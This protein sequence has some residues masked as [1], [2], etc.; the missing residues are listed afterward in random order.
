MVLEVPPRGTS[1]TDLP[2]AATLLF[3][4]GVGLQVAKPV[5]Q[6]KWSPDRWCPKCTPR[7]FSNRPL[8]RSNRLLQNQCRFPGRQAGVPEKMVFEPMVPEV[9][10]EALPLPT[11][12]LQQRFC[13]KPMSASRSP[14]RGSEKTVP[15]PM[16]P[17]MPPEALPQPTPLPRHQVCAQSMPAPMGTYWPQSPAGIGPDHPQKS[18][19]EAD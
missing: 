10:P 14:G 17:E 9:P 2:S 13:S 18:P 6:K 1:L 3:Q 5:V 12:S 15:G 19:P 11:F 7:H 8:F 16:V 4:T